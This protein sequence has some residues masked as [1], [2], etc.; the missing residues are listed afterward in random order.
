MSVQKIEFTDAN[1]DAETREGLS[2]VCFEDPLDRECR[3]EAAFVEKAANTIAERIKLGNCDIE[4]CPTLA[5]RFRVTSIPTI[6]IIRD[7]KEVERLT[8]FRH[9]KA[10][11]KHLKKHVGDDLQ[12]L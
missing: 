12:D 1:F 7:G 9:E 6:L 3:K 11:V 5:E 4:N 2:V 8:G 10:L